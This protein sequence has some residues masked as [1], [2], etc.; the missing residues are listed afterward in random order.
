MRRKTVLTFV[1]IVI[2]LVISIGVY[3]YL[4][5]IK[6]E[7]IV[8]RTASFSEIDE[9][10]KRELLK[11][12]VRDS[13]IVKMV[14]E[15][16]ENN[17]IIWIQLT[18][19]VLVGDGVLFEDWESELRTSLEWINAEVY[20]TIIDRKQDSITLEI[21]KDGLVMEIVTLRHRPSGLY[22]VAIILD[23]LG[24]N[25]DAVMKYLELNIP[26][27]YAILPHTVHSDY[28]A[29]MLKRLGHDTLLHLPCEPMGYPGVNPGPGAI[30]IS[31][32]PSQ[33][34]STILHGLST[35]PGVL[36]VNNHQGSRA[37]SDSKIVGYML[38][39]IKSKKLFFVDSRTSPDSRGYDIAK[40]LGM[41]T[42]VNNIFLDNE[43][44]YEYVA[45]QMERLRVYVKKY[46]K[47]VAI[48]HVTRKA[49]LEVLADYKPKFKSDGIEFVYIS[50]LL[51]Q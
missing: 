5:N 22:K 39:T 33:I 12:G 41:K 29:R 1:F 6:E 35:V 15:E 24:Y 2:L 46:G 47:A 4:K 11:A 18:K 49:T 9:V 27:T 48:G 51:D 50:E 14:H 36:G 21:G 13:D 42:A 38:N 23:D 37:M 16:K 3:R 28:L 44:R 45:S 8:D 10:V 40:E 32:K 7:I 30:L 17:S 20:R 25:K 26:L 34:R 19:E 31:M 43:D